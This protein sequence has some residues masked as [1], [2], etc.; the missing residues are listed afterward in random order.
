MIDAERKAWGR[1]YPDHDKL[2]CFE[3]GRQMHPDTIT[4]RFNRLVDRTGLPRTRLHEVRHS[5][6]TV[7]M[8]AGTNPKLVSERI[9]HSN[10]GFTMQ[11]YVQRSPGLDK[12]AAASIAGV[13]MRGGRKSQPSVT[14]ARWSQSW[15]L[16][17]KNGPAD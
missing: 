8:D 11:T 2:F 10:V 4:R 16:R 5:Y 9:G 14:E 17:T 15:S 7:A 13:I 12:E 1:R 6:A 3:D